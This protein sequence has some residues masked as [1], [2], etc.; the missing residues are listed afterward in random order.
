[1]SKRNVL[2]A[3]GVV[4]V[5]ALWYLFRPELLFVNKTVNE[6][7]PPMTSTSAG[8]MVPATLAAGQFHNGAHDT[9][10]T[11]TIYQADAGKR[12]LRLTNF[13]TSNGPD[14][15]VYLVAA[16]DATDD[17]TVK[18][19]GFLDLGSIKGNEG[20]QNYDLPATADLEK[21]RAVTIWCARFNVNFGTAP[22]QQLRSSTANAVPA[23]VLAGPFHNGAHDTSGTASIYR[24]DSGSQILRLTNFKTSNGPDV[25][26]YLV[27]ANDASDNDT[28]TQ[29]GFTDLGSL[30][31]NE[32]DQNY[33][34]P[35]GVD[36]AKY[37]A[38]TIWCKRFSVN[39]GTAP[40]TPP[41][42][43]QGS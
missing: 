3:S 40:L 11:A 19:A 15:H 29:A 8:A 25:H 42:P 4:V 5:A 41:R 36:L 1:M 18:N 37:R 23:P 12:L 16:S 33:E 7:L 2:V 10:G 38:V 27:A 22:L 24:A 39:F 26:V 32:G 30:K 43:A 14:V 34:V 6:A 28:V 9:A 17:A 20:D 21:Y 13:K 31:G 35:A